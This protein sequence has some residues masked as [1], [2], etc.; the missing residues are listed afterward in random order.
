MKESGS[1]V[2]KKEWSE[3]RKSV[4]VTTKLFLSLFSI[5][6]QQIG[7]KTTHARFCLLLTV[8]FV[9]PSLE[10]MSNQ[11][12]VPEG[13]HSRKSSQSLEARKVPD[14]IR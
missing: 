2:L 11:N 8:Q 10:R 14:E 4:C 13:T 5:Y 7:G 12:S 1:A 3:E 9:I 6:E